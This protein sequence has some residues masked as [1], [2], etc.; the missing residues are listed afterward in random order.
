[1]RKLFATTFA[2]VSVLTL[3]A[4]HAAVPP[5]ESAAAAAGPV[6]IITVAGP[7]AGLQPV[8]YDEQ[9]NTLQA[10]AAENPAVVD[11]LRAQNLTTSDVIDLGV[12][13]G[14][15]SVYVQG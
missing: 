12:S 6:R 3:A 13:N 10:R 8:G 4:A 11:A 9:L 5:A 14:V 2:A 15:V 7:Y 1:M